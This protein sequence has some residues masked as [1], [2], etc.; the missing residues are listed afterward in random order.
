[1]LMERL[2]S[3]SSEIWSYVVS[4]FCWFTPDHCDRMSDFLGLF[5]N[6]VGL[7]IGIPTLF[8]ITIPIN[9]NK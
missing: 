3:C 8:F 2:R 7:S 9:K 5:S 6:L 1:M 4:F